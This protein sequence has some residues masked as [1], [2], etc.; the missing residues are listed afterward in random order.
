MLLRS[1][2]MQL[3]LHSLIDQ[4]ALLHIFESLL[5][6]LLTVLQCGRRVRLFTALLDESLF[7]AVLLD[8]TLSDH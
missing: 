5:P 6:D 8:N 2:E 3:C 7:T 4:H 1:L